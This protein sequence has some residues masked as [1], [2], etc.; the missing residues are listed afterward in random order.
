MTDSTAV[1]ALSALANDSRLRL[2]KALVRAGP[3]G[4]AAGQIAQAI[5][6]TPSR[7]SFHLAA[8]SEAGLVSQTRV[9][10]HVIYRVEFGAL[11]ALMGY[12]LHDCCAGHPKV[13]ACC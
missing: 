8:L 2:I 11:G 4:L 3:E 13:R 6:A 12:L 7:T 1:A 5:E 10:R 9:A